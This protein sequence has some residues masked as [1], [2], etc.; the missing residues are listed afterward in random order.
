MR[1][2]VAKLLLYDGV[3]VTLKDENG[4]TTY[5]LAMRTRDVNFVELLLDSTAE[6]EKK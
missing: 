4:N 6:Q 5:Q 2:E 3:D 1:I